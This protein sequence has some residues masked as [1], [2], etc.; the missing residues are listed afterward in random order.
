MAVA[1]FLAPRR[2]FGLAD[3]AH[4]H[5]V[6]PVRTREGRDA[7]MARN[8]TNRQAGFNWPLLLGVITTLFLL[9]LW[10]WS[11]TQGGPG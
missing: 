1:A 10:W 2:L 3:T 4:A 7:P 5:E 9:W 8:R 6:V 11:A